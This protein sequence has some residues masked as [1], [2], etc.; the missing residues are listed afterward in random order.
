MFL[1]NLS[2]KLLDRISYLVGMVGIL[3][4]STSLL[5][6]V[7]NNWFLILRV[8][9]TGD[10]HHITNKELMDVFDKND[11]EG[12]FFT[13]N[14]GKLQQDVKKI[15]WVKDVVVERS[16]PDTLRI[17]IEEYSAIA[18]LDGQ[19]LISKD[20]KLF[21]GVASNDSLPLFDIN[22]SN[23]PQVIKMYNNINSMLKGHQVVVTSLVYRGDRLSK[24]K[25]SNNLE[26]V[27]CGDDI[28]GSFQ[29]LDKYWNQLY[30]IDP[31]L[32]YVNMCY[33][34]ALAIS[35]FD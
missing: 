22:P 19:G 5:Y 23:I 11:I 20:G 32:K 33:R 31:Q 26:V 14:I 12:T 16:F 24:F 27:I 10:I 9:V 29:L 3:I 13:L 7:I 25:F 28:N 15:P 18:R 1:E 34:N 30:N 17:N 8:V 35:H 4:I 6:Y 2:V 21:K